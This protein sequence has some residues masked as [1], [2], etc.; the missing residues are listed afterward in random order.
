MAYVQAMDKRARKAGIARDRIYL[1]R[2]EGDKYEHQDAVQKQLFMAYT[3]SPLVEAAIVW[4]NGE[5]F[6]KAGTPSLSRES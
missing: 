6:D 5:T 1:L 2:S 3:D 4:I